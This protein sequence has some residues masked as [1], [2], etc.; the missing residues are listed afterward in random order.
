[1]LSS[2]SMY[3]S[4][5]EKILLKSC[6]ATTRAISFHNSKKKFDQLLSSLSMY[7][8][9]IWENICLSLAN[10]QPE[11]YSFII[12]TKKLNQLLSSLS[13]YWSLHWENTCLSLANLQQEQYLFII[14]TKKLN[15]LLSSLSMYW[16][17]IYDFRQTIDTKTE[18]QIFH[19]YN[20][21]PQTWAWQ[22]SP[23]QRAF[24]LVG[25][26]AG[27]E[28]SLDDPEKWNLTSKLVIKTKNPL[29]ENPIDIIL[30]GIVL[31]FFKKMAAICDQDI[32]NSRPS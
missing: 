20:Q 9:L 5:F 7:W 24:L 28:P 15:R 31:T 2:L 32:K 1:M 19:C 27:T 13:M 26:G 25:L 17:M 6:K 14:P 8:S 10:L 11:Q 21:S 29:H 23:R 12:P 18:D 4:L 30:S 22:R 3:W 16:S